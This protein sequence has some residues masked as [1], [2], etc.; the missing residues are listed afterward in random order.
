MANSFRIGWS[1]WVFI[2]TVDKGS[3]NIPLKHKLVSNFYRTFHW[4]VTTDAK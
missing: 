1:I 4:P 2:P 3:P